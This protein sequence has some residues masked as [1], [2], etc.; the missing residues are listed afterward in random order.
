[1]GRKLAIGLGAA[2]V[3]LVVWQFAGQSE[4]RWLH[5]DSNVAHPGAGSVTPASESE[6]LVHPQGSVVANFAPPNAGSVQSEAPVGGQPG[7]RISSQS[8]PHANKV[9]RA[10]FLAD[11]PGLISEI[12][13]RFL[14]EPATDWGSTSGTEIDQLMLELYS[15]D[16]VPEYSRECRETICY[17]ELVPLR[18]QLWISTHA[19]CRCAAMITAF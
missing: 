12:D 18:P 10:R 1:M 19:F 5:R 11:Q 2:L 7:N 6:P 8:L 14:A 3:A 9:L 15:E 17:M 13:Q 16:G 4:T